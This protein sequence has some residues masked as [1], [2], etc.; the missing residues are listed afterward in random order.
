MPAWYGIIWF[1]LIVFFNGFTVFVKGNWDVSSFIAAYITVPIFFGAWIIWKVVK[2]T[3]LIPLKEIDFTSGR[4]E[5]D[6]MEELD[7]VRYKPD[8]MWKKILSTVF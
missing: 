4:R 7:N 6:E 3:R 8:T 5:L 2:R 1:S